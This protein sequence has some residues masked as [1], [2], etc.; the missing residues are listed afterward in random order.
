MAKIRHIALASLDPAKTAEFFIQGFGVEVKHP[1]AFYEVKLLAPDSVL[2]DITDKPWPGSQ[3][4]A[5]AGAGESGKAN[6]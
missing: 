3:P 4:A 6:R 1:D 2:M 5:V